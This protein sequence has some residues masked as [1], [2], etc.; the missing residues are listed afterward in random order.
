[1]KTLLLTIAA[2]SLAA[3]AA[4]FTASGANAADIQP[5]VD[6]FRS[7]LGANNG[8][9]G[10]FASGRRE[11]NWDAVPNG[12]SAPN[13][14]PGNF[15]NSNSPR[16][17]AMSTPGTGLQV[18][19]NL[20]SGTP[21]EFGN[22]GASYPAH[23]TPFSAERLFTP[24]GSNIVDVTFFV[25]GTTTPGFGAVF[26]DVQAA[27]TTIFTV[28]H[29]NGDNGGQFAI[30]ANAAAGG[31]SFLGLTD[32][33]N[34]YSRIRIQSGQVD[35]GTGTAQ[36][37]QSNLDVVAMDDFIYGEPLALDFWRSGTVQLRAHRCGTRAAGFRPPPLIQSHR[38]Q[39][40]G[41]GMTKAMSPAATLV[42]VD[43]YLRTSYKPACEYRDGV[44]T[45]K[46]RPT[47][48]HAFVISRI[49]K[50]IEAANPN[51]WAVS[52]LSVRLRAERYLVTDVAVQRHDSIQDPNP[53]QPI[54]LCVKVLSPGDRLSETIAKG[55]EY[56]EWGVP[57]V[58]IV[59]PE[60]RVAWEL[61]AEL[62][63]HEAIESLTAGEIAI[64]LARLFAGL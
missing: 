13:L 61:S 57:T 51:V 20:A 7:A 9:G 38:K 18:S 42:P 31:F 48:K 37:L 55:E 29:A 43:E 44:L 54:P 17:L 22:L 19:A 16:G 50:L 4:V 40:F 30:P 6:N 2:A 56:L 59:D 33:T 3:P 36:N 64:P 58:W 39:Y 24:V 34:R 23:L 45:Q 32:P 21:V 47:W 15:F 14:L 62:G 35:L 52:E 12:S 11:I 53:A 49:M 60:K 8:V 26:T 27:S 25:P 1:M 46:L 63:L 28:F 41:R 5:A 10:S